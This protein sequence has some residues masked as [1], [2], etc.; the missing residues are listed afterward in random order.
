MT[1]LDLQILDL[2]QAK[3]ISIS[4]FLVNPFINKNGQCSRPSNNINVKLRQLSEL[5]KK[6]TVNPKKILILLK[7]VDF[8]NKS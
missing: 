5:E 4:R 3:V 6:N 7:T 1:H 2:I 8:A